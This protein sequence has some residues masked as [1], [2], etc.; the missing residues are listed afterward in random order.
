MPTVLI[1]SINYSGQ[2][3]DITFYPQTGGTVG[4]GSQLIPYYYT[5][6][7]VYGTYSLFFSSFNSTCEF[8]LL[9]PTPTPTATITDTPTQTPTPTITPTV[10]VSP[11]PFPACIDC[12]MSGVSFSDVCLSGCYPIAFGIN[13]GASTSSYSIVMTFDGGVNYEYIRNFSP[14]IKFTNITRG[15]SGSTELYFFIA[16][17]NTVFY[18]QNGSTWVNAGAVFPEDAE[19]TAFGQDNNDNFIWLVYASITPSTYSLYYSTNLILW[20]QASISNP[21]SDGWCDFQGTRINDAISYGWDNTGNRLW[22]Q[23]ARASGGGLPDQAISYDGYNWSGVSTGIDCTYVSFGNGVWVKSSSAGST[24]PLYYSYDGII[25]SLMVTSLPTSRTVQC[26]N[27]GNNRFVAGVRASFGGQLNI[28]YSDDGINWTLSSFASVITGTFSQVQYDA[29]NNRWYI[30]GNTSTSFALYSTDNAVSWTESSPFEGLTSSEFDVDACEVLLPTPAPTRTV[31]PTQSTAT[32]SQTPTPT[33]T[34]TPT[35]SITSTRTQT[36][37]QTPTRTVTRTSLTP[38]PT[39]TNTR[40][41]T[42]TPTPTLTDFPCNCFEFTNI[43]GDV[44]F[45]NIRNCYQDITTLEVP[46]GDTVYACGFVESASPVISYSS[47]TSDCATAIQS[48]LDDA[49]GCCMCVRLDV[50]VA[51][52]IWPPVGSSYIN[53]N[54]QSGTYAATTTGL[55]YFCANSQTKFLLVAPSGSTSAYTW[56]IFGG[57][58]SGSCVNVPTPTPTQTPTMTPTPSSTPTGSTC[59]CITLANT[60][61]TND[62]YTYYDCDN[63]FVDPP[64]LSPGDIV[65]FCSL[66][67]TANTDGQTQIIEGISCTGD[68]DCNNCRCITFEN[69]DTLKRTIEY[70]DCAGN[71]NSTDIPPG[72][73]LQFCGIRFYSSNSLVRVTVGGICQDGVTCP[74]E[75]TP[76]SIILF[77]NSIP[78]AFLYDHSSNTLTQLY[79]PGAYNSNDI[80]RNSNYLWIYESPGGG[81]TPF[82]QYNISTLNPSAWTY[83]DYVISA[84]TGLGLTS[85]NSSDTVFAVSGDGNTILRYTMSTGGVI[86]AANV[87]SGVVVYDWIYNSSTGEIIITGIKDGDF[88]IFQWDG[89]LTTYLNNGATEI[90]ALYQ[91]GSQLFYIEGNGDVYQIGTTSPYTTTYI[92][93]IPGR[94]NFAGAAQDDPS[95]ITVSFT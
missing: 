86:L 15:Y 8:T 95:M 13:S 50:F 30:V 28:Y 77:D 74:F 51:P 43:G 83:S 55:Q 19:F 3:S 75:L 68:T 2:V 36:P 47:V 10:T 39:P 53:C 23:V 49:P 67:Y 46:V 26:L 59:V 21:Q 89:T 16:N 38:T 84:D 70:T 12:G 9:A 63:N 65:S 35:P 33:L 87:G 88:G 60:G 79:L 85:Y 57:C 78:D 54:G 1:S 94:I 25:W 91:Y 6:D 22:I 52:S 4:L 93:S 37:T 14:Y 7:Y 64:K 27:F 81:S 82:R 66:S 24:K 72:E 48:V 29:A 90:V 76:E 20:T 80:A 73:I 5:A 42:F 62:N 18:S 92:Q 45:V 40:T 69:T 11:S 32:E 17:N 31:T 61:D 41:P 34:Q 58:V 71:L 44:G 56:S